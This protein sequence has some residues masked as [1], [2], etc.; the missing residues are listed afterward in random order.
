[1]TNH[2]LLALAAVGAIGAGTAAA[3]VASAHGGGHSHTRVVR[4]QIAAVE[5]YSS[6]TLTLKTTGGQTV[7]GKVTRSTDIECATLASS[8]TTPTTPTDTTPTTPSQDDRGGRGGGR[9]DDGPSGHRWDYDDDD[10]PICDTSSLASGVS[11]AGAQTALTKTGQKFTDVVLIVPASS[12][13][14]DYSN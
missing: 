8:A 11:V 6:G 10:E 9:G 3:T 4:S 14:S 2:R 7:T 1:M 5:S 13:D 12:S